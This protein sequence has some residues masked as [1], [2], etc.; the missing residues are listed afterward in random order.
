MPEPEPYAAWSLSDRLKM[1]TFEARLA[2]LPPAL[3]VALWD[4]IDR[5]EGPPLEPPNAKSFPFC[6]DPTL[7]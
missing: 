1:L 5:L 4:A 6:A 3:I 7:T 2:H